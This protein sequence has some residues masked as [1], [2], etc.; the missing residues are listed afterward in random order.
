MPQKL[1]L[2]SPVNVDAA[3]WRTWENCLFGVV[4]RA[5][6][7]DAARSITAKQA[8]DEGPD[9]W[10]SSQMTKCTELTADGPSLAILSD[11]NR[12]G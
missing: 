5:V 1:W 9:A 10:L 4:A 6:T 7:E 11:Y 2:L 8:A 3:P 12:P